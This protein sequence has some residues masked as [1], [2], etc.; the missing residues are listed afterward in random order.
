MLKLVHR[1]NGKFTPLFSELNPGS[2]KWSGIRIGIGKI[3]RRLRQGGIS[4]VR[5]WESELLKQYEFGNQK[6]RKRM[7][8]NGRLNEKTYSIKT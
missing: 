6:L 3:E 4:V 5:V 8:Q 2:K 1:E 7:K